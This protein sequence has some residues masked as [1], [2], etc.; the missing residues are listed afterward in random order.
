MITIKLH[1]FLVQLQIHIRK[2]LLFHLLDNV[3]YTGLIRWSVIHPISLPASL[4]VCLLVC[5]PLS[6]CLPECLHPP[7]CL[8]SN[9]PLFM[10]TCLTC[11]CLPT[12]FPIFSAFQSVFQ[13]LTCQF[14][15]GSNHLRSWT[16]GIQVI[17]T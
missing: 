4:L 13:P 8:P 2:M 6:A 9:Q 11:T 16:P 7:A 10:P 12:C 14:S 1:R 3:S 17:M 5:L 15:R